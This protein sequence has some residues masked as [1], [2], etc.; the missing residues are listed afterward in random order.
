MYIWMSDI[1]ISTGV[2]TCCNLDGV[3]GIEGRRSKL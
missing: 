2:G 3:L 1:D